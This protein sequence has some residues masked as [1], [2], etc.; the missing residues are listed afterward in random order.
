MHEAIATEPTPTTSQSQH[1]RRCRG[2]I[3]IGMVKAVK[4]ASDEDARRVVLRQLSPEARLLLETRYSALGWYP[5]T[6][7]PELFTAF[8]AVTGRTPR[9]FAHYV[10]KFVARERPG[11]VGRGI[12]RR[13]GSPDRFAS[14]IEILFRLLYDSGNVT[15]Q[16]D[17]RTRT[18]RI[19]VSRWS[20]HCPV[21]CGTVTG[22]FEGMVTHFHDPTL[23]GTELACCVSDGAAC[24]E[25][26]YS[27]I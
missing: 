12:L 5:M 21:L 1:G 10:G 27:F 24:C 19:Q 7:V 11:P 2:Q 23:M 26:V 9:E 17:V 6:G 13:F 14:Y 25:H 8:G 16:Y 18:L 20:G 15:G 4:R 22:A 3:A